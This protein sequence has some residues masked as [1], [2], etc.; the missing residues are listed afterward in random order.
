MKYFENKNRLIYVFIF[1][2]I[3]AYSQDY[4]TD[5]I[6]LWEG[7]KVPFN[8]ESIQLKETLD[9]EGTRYTQISEP[10]IYVYRNKDIK[11]K[12]EQLF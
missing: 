8:K 2:C 5:T 3:H 12:M 1:M 9:E 11:K 6:K 7:E 4:S 10:A